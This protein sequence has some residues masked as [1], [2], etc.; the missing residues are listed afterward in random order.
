[1]TNIIKPDKFTVRHSRKNKVEILLDGRKICTLAKDIPF[2]IRTSIAY[3][4][5]KRL[6]RD[7]ENTKDEMFDEPPFYLILR[8]KVFRSKNKRKNNG[9]TP[10]FSTD[11]EPKS[12][13]QKPWRTV[14]I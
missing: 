10:L 14:Y 5:A 9:E 2:E 4:M 1:M 6:N 8:E 3:S 12:T 7:I 13:E 11:T